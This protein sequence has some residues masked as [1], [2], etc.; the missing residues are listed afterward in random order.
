MIKAKHQIYLDDES[1][2]DRKLWDEVLKYRIN[3]RM[4]DNNEAVLSLIRIGLRFKTRE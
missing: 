3:E 4:K 1:E 2:K